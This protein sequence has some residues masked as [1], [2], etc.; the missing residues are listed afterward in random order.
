MAFLEAPR[1]PDAIARGARGGPEFSTD[2]E[3]LFS[4]AEAG[5]INRDQ[6][7]GRWSVGHVA[8]PLSEFSELLK[9]FRAVRGRGHRFRFKDHM[10]F[11]AT[12]A[13]G[14]VTLISGDTY[15]MWKRY[16]PV[17]SS[18][19]EDYKVVKPVSPTVTVTGGGSYTVAY[20]TGV[21]T[22]VSGAVPTGWS[23]EFD[24]PC[25]FNIDHMA[26]AQLIDRQG[27]SGEI[28]CVWDSIEIFEVLNP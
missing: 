24:K 13:E 18:L 2:I 14:V 7:L 23:G 6:A 4:G 19:F 3:T 5:N 1:F 26:D 21:I 25:R 28:L 11:A 15:Q 12:T 16:Q 8:K 17:G 27:G 10:D 9:F 20:T 22:R